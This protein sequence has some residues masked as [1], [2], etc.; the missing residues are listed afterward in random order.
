[1]EGAST[2]GTAPTGG[3]R[4]AGRIPS[5]G[6]PPRR[7]GRKAPTGAGWL[8]QGAGVRGISRASPRGSS[9][10]TST[11]TPD[12]M[13]QAARA[14]PAS[15]SPAG[16]R[17]T[18]PEAAS[19]GPRRDVPSELIRGDLRRCPGRRQRGPHRHYRGDAAVGVHRRGG[20]ATP[21]RSGQAAL[22]G[23]PRAL[24]AVTAECVRVL[25]PSDVPMG[26][27]WRQVRRRWWLLAGFAQ[28]CRQQP[29]AMAVVAAGTRRTNG[30]PAAS[31]QVP[32]CCSTAAVHIRCIDQLSL[33][34]C[35]PGDRVEAWRPARVGDRPGCAAPRAV[36]P[37]HEGPRYF[38]A[39]WR[40]PPDGDTQRA[41][42]SAT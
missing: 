7:P 21:V 41:G 31:R 34:H 10:R 18:S 26:Q 6:S 9:A 36:V 35:G 37:L 38:S 32:S 33:I 30:E 2:N 11:D 8:E 22:G 17:A 14:R 29:T 28:Q 42:R 5:P 13:P 4:P 39:G 23:V 19:T 20:S 16:A 3:G 12:A 15:W 1:M 25:K 24:W 27:P 40:D